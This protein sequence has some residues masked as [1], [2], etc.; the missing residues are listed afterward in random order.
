[1]QVFKM[2]GAKA[3]E[4]EALSSSIVKGFVD[5]FAVLKRDADEAR[6]ML[7]KAK[8]QIV[9]II[10]DGG[11]IDV[12]SDEA[13][14]IKLQTVDSAVMVT[15]KPTKVGIKSQAKLKKAI[16]DVDS[17]EAKMLEGFVEIASYKIKEGV[18]VTVDDDLFEVK[19]TAP[20]VQTSKREEL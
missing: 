18:I 20:T 7:D 10:K 13:I 9:E 6:K 12:G 8:K 5:D 16:D 1:M 17:E 19:E 2:D 15:Y 11:Y 14:S 3:I 4:L